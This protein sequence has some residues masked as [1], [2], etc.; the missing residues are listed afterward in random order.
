M[1]RSGAFLLDDWRDGDIRRFDFEGSPPDDGNI[2]R[3][4]AT[5]LGA[6]GP[7]F[8]PW[9][10]TGGRLGTVHVVVVRS[11]RRNHR[12]YRLRGPRCVS[13]MSPDDWLCLVC[14]DSVLLLR[15]GTARELAASAGP[16]LWRVRVGDGGYPA[17]FVGA[18]NQDLLGGTVSSAHAW[19]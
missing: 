6:A 3:R 12:V 17:R 16:L 8:A 13:E 15:I 7:Q 9:G 10:Q 5:A 18:D 1:R 11:D 14:G 19:S 4:L 2:L